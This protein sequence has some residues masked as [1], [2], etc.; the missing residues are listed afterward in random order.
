M[1]VASAILS[2]AAA[3]RIAHFAM[4]GKS[5]LCLNGTGL[6]VQFAGE[7]WSFVRVSVTSH[8]HNG[9]VGTMRWKIT[10]DQDD[11]TLA[12]ATVISALAISLA[13]I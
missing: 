2:I 13:L 9:E 1:A 7:P 3:T 12:V 6:P 11:L 8:D 5:V 4:T 10:F